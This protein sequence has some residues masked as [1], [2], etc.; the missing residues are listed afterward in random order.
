MSETNQKSQP[1]R[2]REAAREAGA[3]EADD[4]MDKAMSK[5]DLTKKPEDTP[6][7]K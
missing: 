6:N 4:A 2:F 7:K 1:D 5:L 3:D